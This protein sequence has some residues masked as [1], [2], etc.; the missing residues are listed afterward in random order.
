MWRRWYLTKQGNQKIKVNE[1]IWLFLD[2]MRPRKLISCIKRDLIKLIPIHLCVLCLRNRL[3]LAVI[4][5]VIN[6]S[7][8]IGCKVDRITSGKREWF[9][10][11]QLT[12]KRWFIT[13]LPVSILTQRKWRKIIVSFRFCHRTKISPKVLTLTLE[14]TCVSYVVDARKPHYT[15]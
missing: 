13:H 12:D 10:N 9:F 8:E 2:R 11:L 7:L 3:A 5:W 4:C 14:F 1:P 6:H 15:V